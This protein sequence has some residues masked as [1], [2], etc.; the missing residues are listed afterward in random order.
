[1]NKLHLCFLLSTFWFVSSFR[2]SA[3]TYSIDWFTVDAGG[4]TSSG[5]TFSVNGTIGQP[6]AGIM[7]GGQFSSTGGFWSLISIVQTPAAPLLS[8]QLLNNAVRVY[9]PASAGGFVLDESPTPSGGWSQV[10]IPY[11]TNALEISI[12]VTNP[13]GNKFYRLRK[14]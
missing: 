1:M 13:P 3:Q 7:N 6:D 4:G 10:T 11:V 9:W 5:G 2:V 8:L 12:T 14:P